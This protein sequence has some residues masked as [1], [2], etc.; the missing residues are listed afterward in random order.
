MRATKVLLVPSG[1]K[2]ESAISSKN[3]TEKQR[4]LSERGPEV[5]VSTCTAAHLLGVN[6]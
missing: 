3:E 6:K 2:E 1:L 4:F 5:T